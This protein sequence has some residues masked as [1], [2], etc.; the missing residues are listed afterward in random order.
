MGGGLGFLLLFHTAWNIVFEDWLKHQL[1]HFFG[2]TVAEM[3]ERFGAVGFP[4]LGAIGLVWFLLRYAKAHYAG[5]SHD[6]M[7]E[8]Q[9]QHTAAILAQT[10]AWNAV[11]AREAGPNNKDTNFFDPE[12]SLVADNHTW[13]SA[14]S[15]IES[16]AG[17]HLIN[18]RN[19]WKE[20]FQESY[21]L[22]HEAR[23]RIAALQNAMGGIFG[24]DASGELGVNQRKFR[25]AQMKRDMAK[26]ELR[27]AWDALRADLEGKLASGSLIAKGFRAPH[28]AGSAEVT[29]ASA[30]WRILTLNNAQSEALR[31]GSP[32]VL[33]SGILIR[34]AG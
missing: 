34:V 19:K 2:H 1:E 3:I 20:A 21:L 15:A 10:E 28:T 5:T 6:P 12:T 26:D 13:E 7:V 23:D 25:A 4:A 11:S 29:I 8:A 24:T 17:I 14:E 30:E 27:S 31:R 22:M 16:F 32:D 9:R 33:Y 18:E